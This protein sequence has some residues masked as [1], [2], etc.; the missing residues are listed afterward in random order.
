MLS[1]RATERL[2][3]RKLLLAV[4]GIEAVIGRDLSEHPSPRRVCRP[5]HQLY[6]FSA[7]GWPPL[8]S[9]ISEGCDPHTLSRRIG[10]YNL[11]WS[12]T[13]AATV[14]VAGTLLAHWQSGVFLVPLAVL[15]IALAFLAFGLKG[16]PT[17]PATEVPPAHVAPEPD[18]LRSRTLALWLSRIVLPAEYVVIYGIAAMMPLL[19]IVQELSPGSRRCWGASG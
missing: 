12:G 16:A 13:G 7:A 9:L 1:S 4:H 14:A 18:L 6:L 3:H 17:Q 19:S 11:V 8:E 15:L 2:G 10:I 5:A